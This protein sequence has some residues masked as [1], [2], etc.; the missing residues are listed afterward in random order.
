MPSEEDPLT[1]GLPIRLFLYTVDQMATLMAVSDDHVKKRYL[2]YE[3]RNVGPRPRDRM[4][5]RNIAPEGTRPDWRVAEQEFVR[6]LRSK[7][8]KVHDRT[9]VS[10]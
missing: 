5:A 4:V 8:F 3:G 1:V 10:R 2:W 9:W 7:G 6:F